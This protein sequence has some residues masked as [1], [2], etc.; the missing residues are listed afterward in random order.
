[1][2]A[3]PVR[4]KKREFWLMD[5]FKVEKN[6]QHIRFDRLMIFSHL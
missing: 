6:Q 3:K 5:N 2:P 1:M 4:R